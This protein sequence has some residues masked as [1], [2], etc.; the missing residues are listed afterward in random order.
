MYGFN[1]LTFGLLINK[2]LKATCITVFGGN[3]VMSLFN[4]ANLEQLHWF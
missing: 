1:L 3:Q 4:Y 2:S